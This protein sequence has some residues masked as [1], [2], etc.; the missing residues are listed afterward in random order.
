MPQIWKLQNRVTREVT[1]LMPS[2]FKMLLL[3]REL[4]H[5][6]EGTYSSW[7]K[8]PIIEAARKFQK[9]VHVV[10]AILREWHS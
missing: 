9:R 1:S 3:F 2:V 10:L 7:Q 6:M 8:I 4:L 5:N